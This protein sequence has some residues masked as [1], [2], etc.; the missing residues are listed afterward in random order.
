MG[1]GLWWM[2]GDARGILGCGGE[3]LDVDVGKV[4]MG[5]GGGYGQPAN[6]I[7]VDLRI[8]KVDFWGLCCECEVVDVDV[9]GC[10]VKVLWARL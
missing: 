9:C 7:S 1:C 6:A 2:G 5:P 8:L 3:D 10:E 4:Y